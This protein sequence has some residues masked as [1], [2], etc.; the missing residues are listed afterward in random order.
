M[1]T[2]KKLEKNKSKNFNISEHDKQNSTIEE[3]EEKKDIQN[4]S[5]TSYAL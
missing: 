2:N 5:K 4:Y 1:K 3:N